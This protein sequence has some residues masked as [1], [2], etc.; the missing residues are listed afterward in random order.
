[1]I[2]HQP[3]KSRERIQ[4]YT[5]TA[6]RRRNL[7]AGRE[8]NADKFQCAM[9]LLNASEGANLQP[10][11][12]SSIPSYPKL[13]LLSTQGRTLITPTQGGTN[14]VYNTIQSSQFLQEVDVSDSFTA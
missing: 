1:M 10:K 4:N 12:T 14:N 13:S 8:L 5:F 6:T 2:L 11:F 9:L 7:S 3:A